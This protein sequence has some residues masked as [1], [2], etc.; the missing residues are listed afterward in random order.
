MNY[1]PMFVNLNGR[2][3]LIVGGGEVGYLKA[4]RLLRFGAEITVVSNTFLPAFEELPVERRKGEYCEELLEGAALVV[5][6]TD[7]SALNA[8]IS[9]DCADR[10]IPINCVD[11]KSNCTFFF[12]AYLTRGDVT[13]GVSTG[14]E[15][16][17]V[18]ALV[19][20]RIDGFLPEELGERCARAAE[21]RKRLTKA[22]YMACVKELFD[23]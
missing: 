5:A 3:C 9:A 16:P 10:K 22:E 2:R 23:D 4:K 15:A 17:A 8:K 6:A 11:D 7:D 13:V 12:P 14:G 20:D 21:A 1:F 19:R 18:C